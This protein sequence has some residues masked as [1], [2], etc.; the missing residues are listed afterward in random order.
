MHGISFP[1]IF[2]IV[3]DITKKKKRDNEKKGC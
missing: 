3:S 1:G 2:I